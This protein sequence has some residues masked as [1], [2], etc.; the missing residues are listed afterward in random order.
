MAEAADVVIVGAGPAGLAA[1][2]ELRRRGIERVVV[3]DREG[4]AGGIP[5][6]CGHYPFGMREFH[7]VL[8]GP[9]YAAR[10]VARAAAAG[11]DIRTN[12][13]VTALAPGGRLSLSTPEGLAE[14]TGRA[15]LLATGVRETS[16]SGR[17]MGGEKPG[18][19]LS[20]GALQG[21]VYL[22]GQKPFTRPAIV[23][24]ELVAFSALLTCRHAGIRP[25]A[26]IEAGP[27]PVALAPATLLARAMGVP[28]LA[29]TSVEAILGR[30][31]VERLVL[32]GADSGRREIEADGVIVSGMF[33]PEA[34][35]LAGSHLAVDPATRGPEID[36]FG[37]LSDP[38]FFAA[39]NV[40]RP[41]ETAGWCWSEGVA[42]A[43]AIVAALDGRLPERRSGL[44]IRL[45]SDAL[46]LAV[47][48]VLLPGAN[49]AAGGGQLQVRL[50]RPARGRLLL[51]RGEATIAARHI[52][53]RPERRILLRVPPLAAAGEGELRLELEES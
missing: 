32:A 48:Q 14:L 1:A 25:V 44:R 10:L 8:R 29:R 40:L 38:A 24:S 13:T 33:R 5:R 17:L 9:D 6:H 35:L 23:G 4:S 50:A 12:I 41:V 34:T 45:A 31:S 2:T 47:P 30:D 22:N 49:G 7:R 37:R 11:V 52:D 51:K 18:G 15:V 28:F 20:T 19:V 21:L 43:R 26:M 36:P 27:R 39:G 16:R 42:A 3:V 53:S 46:K